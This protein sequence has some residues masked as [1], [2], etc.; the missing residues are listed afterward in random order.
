MRLDVMAVMRGVDPFPA[1]WERRTTVETAD[2]GRLDILALPD[3]VQAKKTQRDKDWPMIRRLVEAHFAQHE[4]NP[5]TEHV[6]FWLQEART[7]ALLVLLAERFPAAASEGIPRRP[8][9]DHA[10]RGDAEGL[11]LALEQE[12]W[13]ER[14]RDRAYWLLLVRELEELRHEET[15]RGHARLA[16]TADL[17]GTGDLG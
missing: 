16:G 10:R 14:A 7:P 8:L 11:E 13:A 1:L 9:L 3:L 17:P 6:Q 15:C 4:S 12:A 2:G 5:A